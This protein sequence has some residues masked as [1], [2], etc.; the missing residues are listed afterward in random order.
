MADDTTVVTT[1]ET[2]ETTTQ[3]D[4]QR[5]GFIS[6]ILAIVGLIIVLIIVFWGLIHFANLLSPWFSS[7][8]GPKQT[9]S[10]LHVSAPTDAT[11][12]TPFTVRWTY[13]TTAAGTYAFLYPCNDSLHFKTVDAA[14]ASG[15]I[16]CGAAFSVASSSLTV[17]PVLSGTK[18]VD[19]PLT[20]LFVPTL[21][22]TQAQGSATVTI[23]PGTEPVQVAKPVVHSGPADL[24]VQILS[25]TVDQNGWAVVTFDIANVGSGDSGSYSFVAYLPTNSTYTYYSPVQVSLAPG[26]HIVN[27]LRFSQANSGAIAVLVDPSNVVNDANRTNNYA[28]QNLVM[29]ATYNPQVYYN[30]NQYYQPPVVY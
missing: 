25:A 9:T 19:E 13:S 1:T 24:S 27:T 3:A 21:A 26:S 23:N 14:G 6:N 11:S 5:P 2:T 18:S 8:F 4:E 29:P 7:L 20:I 16:P 15:E 30:N 22:G 28:A 17:I 10:A 12:G